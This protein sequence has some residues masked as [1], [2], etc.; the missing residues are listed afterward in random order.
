MVISTTMES[1]DNINGNNYEVNQQ[2]RWGNNSANWIMQIANKTKAMANK[3]KFSHNS[4]ENISQSKGQA[5]MHKHNNCKNLNYLQF[6][7]RI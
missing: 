7:H 2:H 4:M 1:I 5:K 3:T 6:K